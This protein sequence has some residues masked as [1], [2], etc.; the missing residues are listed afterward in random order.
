MSNSEV[1]PTIS[2]LREEWSSVVGAEDGN[3][4]R[5]LLSGTTVRVRTRRQTRQALSQ[6]IRSAAAAGTSRGAD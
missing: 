3:K 6:P 5:R 2:F 4:W 1:L